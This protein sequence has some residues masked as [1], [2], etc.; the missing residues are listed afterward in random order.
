MKSVSQ[1]LENLR[2]V[3][4]SVK[5]RNCGAVPRLIGKQYTLRCPAC[6]FNITVTPNYLAGLKRAELRAR[7]EEYKKPVK[8]RICKDKGYVVL[9][10]QVDDSIFTFAY[11]CPCQAGQKREDMAAWP[12]AP[13]EKVRDV[14][15]P[16][17]A[18]M[19]EM[20]AN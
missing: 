18:E 6:G 9:E 8:C 10:E 12:V 20:F 1:I 5:C 4:V 19:A 11:R 2:D 16:T 14:S 17:V 7:G 3:E 13:L 15:K